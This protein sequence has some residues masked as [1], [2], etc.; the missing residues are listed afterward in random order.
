MCKWLSLVIMIHGSEHWQI[1]KIMWNAILLCDRNSL[2]SYFSVQ[3]IDS[4][5]MFQ[6]LIVTAIC[7]NCILLVCLYDQEGKWRIEPGL[8]AILIMEHLLLLIKFG[9]SNFVPE[10]PAWV[11]ANRVR[12]VVQARDMYSKQ[13]LRSIS[14]LEMKRDWRKQRD[15][16]SLH[17]DW[18]DWLALS[19]YL[20][21]C[22]PLQLCDYPSVMVEGSKIY[23]LSGA[24]GACFSSSCKV[25]L[26]V[27]FCAK[28]ERKQTYLCYI[29]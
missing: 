17:V 18:S 5:I 14:N 16:E 15:G 7:T 20:C 22:S 4:F 3:L 12:N 8:A 11:K 28:R 27:F 9:F 6:F 1:R 29:M 23:K 24:N 2:C 26:S 13:L 21:G 10:E 19:G 25:F